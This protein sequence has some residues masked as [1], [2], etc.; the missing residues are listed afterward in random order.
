MLF[1][2]VRIQSRSR[3]RGIGTT[4]VYSGDGTGRAL[5]RQRRSTFPEENTLQLRD[6]LIDLSGRSMAAGRNK[7]ILRKL[8]VAVRSLNY[9]IVP[10]TC[11]YSASDGFACY[12]S[13]HEGSI[14][15]ARMASVIYPGAVDSG[16]FGGGIVGLPGNCGGGSRECRLAATTEVRVHNARILFAPHCR[17]L[18]LR[19]RECLSTPSQW[20]SRQS[21]RRCQGRARTQHPASCNQH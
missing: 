8:Y 21:A 5:T 10:R 4:L 2:S 11:V 6:L 12:P 1:R 20:L 3:S 7:V 16:C 13:L 19:S 15:M 17:S 14:R 18:E 9:S